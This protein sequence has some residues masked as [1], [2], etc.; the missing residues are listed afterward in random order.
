ME[1]GCYRNELVKLLL[2]CKEGPLD[3]LTRDLIMDLK[4]YEQRSFLP[5]NVFISK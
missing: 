1:Y 2:K 5:L 4:P 3:E